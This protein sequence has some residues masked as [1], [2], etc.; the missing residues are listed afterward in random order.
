MA[1]PASAHAF[2]GSCGSTADGPVVSA[3]RLAE[4]TLCL[5]NRERLD[6]GLPRLRVDARLNQA[7]VQHVVE[8]VRDHYFG[9]DTPSGRPF[10]W[11]IR[12]FGYGDDGR[13]VVGENQAWGTGLNS[14]PDAVIAAWMASP[15]HRANILRASFRQI[16][17]AV[18]QLTPEQTG[19]AGAPYVAAFGGQ[20]PVPRVRR[21][22]R[23]PRRRTRT[24]TPVHV[25]MAALALLTPPSVDSP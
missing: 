12:T 18:I 1:F 10:F 22:P 16:G 8:M 4:S 2:P 17:L 6:R 25:P 21:P 9:H 15:S 20:P 14:L 11:R 7:S 5:I 24:R 19:E 13:W 23:L 3:D